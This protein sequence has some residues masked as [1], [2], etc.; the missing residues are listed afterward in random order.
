MSERPHDP[1]LTSGDPLDPGPTSRR[2]G[3]PTRRPPTASPPARVGRRRPGA[4]G[5]LDRRGYAAPR[6]RRARYA[7][8][9]WWSRVGAAIIDGLI[10]GVGALSSSRSSVFS[11]GFFASDEAGVGSLIVGHALGSLG[12]DR[13][14]ALRAAD[15][16]AHERQ[17]ARAHGG[18]HPGRAGQRAADDV[19]LGDAARGRGQ[20]AAVRGRW[21]GHRSASPA[22]LDVLWPLWD[23]E[24]RALHDFI[25]DTRVVRD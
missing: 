18:R 25:V 14:A 4:F 23:D 24:N 3:T 15:D 22:S 20:G 19:R 10:I 8:A 17:D 21:L 13:L 5:A 11:V 9:G 12:R 7:L 6:C 1:G 16:G 2:P